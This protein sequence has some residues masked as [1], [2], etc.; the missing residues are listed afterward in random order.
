MKYYENPKYTIEQKFDLMVDRAEYVVDFYLS[1]DIKDWR[2]E[3][4]EIENNTLAGLQ[5][6]YYYMV[7]G[8]K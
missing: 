3:L 6:I 8:G 4:S 1:H 7:Y 5:N 2:Y